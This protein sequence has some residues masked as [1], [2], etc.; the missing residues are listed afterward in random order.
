MFALEVVRFTLI[1]KVT[2]SSR[3][4]CREDV[5]ENL[6]F[7]AHSLRRHWQYWHVSTSHHELYLLKIV[8]DIERVV[9][10]CS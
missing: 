5:E 10:I 4:S 8:W 9:N 3:K 7:S 6:R 2:F 1:T